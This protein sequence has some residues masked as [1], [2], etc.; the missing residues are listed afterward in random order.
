MKRA[1]TL[2]VTVA[3]VGTLMFMGIAGTAAAQDGGL[4]DVGIGDEVDVDQ[5]ADATT[6]VSVDQN[7]DNSQSQSVV[8]ASAGGGDA[9]SH[10]HKHG[11]DKHGQDSSSSGADA[12][13][14]QEQAVSQS[15]DANVENVTS[16]AGN[17]AT[18]DTGLIE[19]GIDIGLELLGA[20]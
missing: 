19:I 13:G 5:D 16:A 10:D 8:A 7:N 15:N 17:N 9:N 2:L 18:V 14:V 12:V 1:F 11:H 3:M 6:D 4:V 20:A